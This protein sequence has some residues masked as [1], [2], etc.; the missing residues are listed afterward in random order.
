M[1]RLCCPVSFIF[2]SFGASG[3]LCFVNVAFPGY[4][5]IFLSGLFLR[6]N[7]EHCSRLKQ[8]HKPYFIIILNGLIDFK[9]A[10]HIKYTMMKSLWMR[11]RWR[12][13]HSSC[14][15][16]L[17]LKRIHHIKAKNTQIKVKIEASRPHP[18]YYMYLFQY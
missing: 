1:W 9:R 11:G 12:P 13:P 15:G 7:M 18:L 2:L 5:Y 16:K 14:A 17:I 6:S 8:R 4:L 10:E 3:A